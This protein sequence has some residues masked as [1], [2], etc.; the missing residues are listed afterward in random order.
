MLD[1]VKTHLREIYNRY[2]GKISSVLEIFIEQFGE[3]NVDSDTVTFDELV[4]QLQKATLGSLGIN[5]FT[6][7]NTYGGYIIDKD[8]YEANGRGK[9]FLDYIPDLGILDYCIPK[10]VQLLKISWDRIWEIKVH[11]PRV[12]VTNEY[13]K[14]IDIQDLYVRVKI[15]KRGELCDLFEM[16]RTTFPY[17]QLRSGYAHSHLPSISADTAGRW[18]HPC[19]GTGPIVETQHTLRSGYDFNI[20]GLFVF[21]LSKY[22]TIESIAGHPFI[23]LESVGRGNVSNI[24]NYYFNPSF[25]YRLFQNIF[26]KFINHCA[27]N[28]IFKIKYVDGEYKIAESP[29]T[30]NIKLSNAYIEWYNTYG[31]TIAQLPSMRRLT[32]EYGIFGE[33]IVCNNSI[34]SI[35]TSDSRGIQ[36]AKNA[37]GKELFKFK[38]KMVKLNIIIDEEMDTENRSLLL[39]SECCS[40]IIT[41][42]LSVINYK[43][44]KRERQGADPK[45]STEVSEKYYFV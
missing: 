9:P 42:A 24:N 39:S 12:R 19:T 10:I 14:F 8:D 41:K 38:G 17:I 27:A 22:V 18:E 36:A 35:Q 26:D 2:Q 6:D 28:N 13:D 20:W 7:T 33:Y 29:L 45:D 32:S 30:A 5:K 31:N 40:Y 34:Y 44:G 11:F 23:R 15:N 4:E 16:T 37:N 43:Y 1:E 25:T 3:E 21:E